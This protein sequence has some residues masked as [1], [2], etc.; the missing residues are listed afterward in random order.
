MQRSQASI[1]PEAAYRRAGGRRR[2]NAQRRRQAEDRRLTLFDL[3]F[4]AGPPWTRRGARAHYARLFG[5]SP[6][7]ITRDIAALY[8]QAEAAWEGEGYAPRT[9]P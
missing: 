9:T 5:V 3:A 1:A 2:Y 4:D 6:A 7:T 8:A